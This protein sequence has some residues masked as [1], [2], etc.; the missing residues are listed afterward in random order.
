MGPHPRP[1]C[2]AWER[3]NAS[4][5]VEGGEVVGPYR[6]RNIGTWGRGPHGRSPDGGETALD[7]ATG[8]W[9]GA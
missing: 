8:R 5:S 7:G 3:I 9:A 1:E 6:V 2:G 4:M